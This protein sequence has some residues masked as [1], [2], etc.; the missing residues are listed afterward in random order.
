MSEFLEKYLVKYTRLRKGEND[1]WIVP[2]RNTE[3]Y[4]FSETTEINKEAY[5]PFLLYF[6]NLSDSLVID[7]VEKSIESTEGKDSFDYLDNL[8]EILSKVFI[9]EFCASLFLVDIAV[10]LDEVDGCLTIDYIKD[11]LLH[12]TGAFF[13]LA[14]TYAET[15]VV[16]MKPDERYP[17]GNAR[18]LAGF[19][20]DENAQFIS[21]VHYS[22]VS[23]WDGDKTAFL[24]SFTFLSSEDALLFEFMELVR[25]DI[26]LKKCENCCRY[27][28]PKTRSD[29]KYCDSLFRDDRTCKQLAFDIKVENDEALRVYR[30]IYKTQNARLHRNSK[31]KSS[32]GKTSLNIR[33]NEWKSNAKQLLEQCRNGSISVEEMKSIIETDSWLKGGAENGDSKKEN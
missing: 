3:N 29:E 20:N 11:N 1:N 15:A 26:I 23:G 5:A 8:Y 4:N 2:K 25:N 14:E 30:S 33:F 10:Y 12:Q 13:M 18:Y 24:D 31:T 6:S 9:D 32:E 28:I 22:N 19:I 27:F 21:N 17:D 16:S 7:D